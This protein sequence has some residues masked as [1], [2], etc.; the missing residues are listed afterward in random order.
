MGSENNDIYLNDKPIKLPLKYVSTDEKQTD[1]YCTWEVTPIDG[2]EPVLTGNFNTADPTI[3]L[4]N[5]PSGQYMLK[6]HII[7]AEEGEQ[8]VDIERMITLYR[9]GDKKKRQQLREQRRHEN[10]NN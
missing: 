4:K 9:K 7:D 10:E 1:T 5:L 8:E 2:K 6:I 3:D